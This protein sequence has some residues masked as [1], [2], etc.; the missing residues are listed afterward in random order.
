M[1]VLTNL[2]VVIILQFI[3]VLNHL[4]TLNLHMLYINY[5]S[6]VEKKKKETIAKKICAYVF[7]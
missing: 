6:T 3:R 2:I 1:E 4:Y 7:F 5:I